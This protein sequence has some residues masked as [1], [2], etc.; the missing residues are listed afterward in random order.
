MHISQVGIC[1]QDFGWI[2]FYTPASTM[3][4]QNGRPKL[5]IGISAK[6]LQVDQELVLKGVEKPRVHFLFTQP[7]ALMPNL[8]SFLFAM[9]LQLHRH[10]SRLEH[11]AAFRLVSQFVDVLV[12][13]SFAIVSTVLTSR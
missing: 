7:S 9:H 6:R 10:R 4:Y 2:P 11:V 1:G 8:S 5:T 3:T 12:C 13:D